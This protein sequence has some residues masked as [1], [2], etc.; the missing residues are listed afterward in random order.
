[1][2]A[3]VVI[4]NSNATGTQAAE[5][6]FKIVSGGA[7][8]TTGV[9]NSVPGSDALRG[10][11]SFTVGQIIQTEQDSILIGQGPGGPIKVELGF[12]NIFKRRPE[13][14]ALNATYDFFPNKVVLDWN[15]DPNTPQATSAGTGHDIYRASTRIQDNYNFV[16]TSYDDDAGLIPGTEYTYTVK[17]SNVFGTDADGDT[18]IGKTSSN[19]TITG[20]VETALGTKIPFTK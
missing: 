16:N 3:Q 17:G 4:S 7:G 2:S 10:T 9:I 5:V 1:M 6:T 18:F 8:N 19:G 12:W 15:Y 13:N 20:F 14:I 11:V